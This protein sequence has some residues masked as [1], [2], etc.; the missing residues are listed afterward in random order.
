MKNIIVYTSNT[1]PYCVTVKEYLKS[2]NL[3]YEEKNVNEN[4]S[5]RKELMA[6]KIMSVPVIKIDNEVV[7]G[8]DQNKIEELLNK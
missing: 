2:N 7:V 6:M 3:K 8:F 1:C 5:Y 4:P